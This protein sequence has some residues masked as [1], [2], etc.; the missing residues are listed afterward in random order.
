MTTLSPP[1]QVTLADVAAHSGV[2]TSSV[3]KV[4]NL[5]AESYRM[6]DQTRQRILDA[7]A[8]LGYRPNFRARSLAKGR[9][10]TIGVL[11]DGAMPS[12]LRDGDSGLISGLE[13]AFRQAEYQMIFLP[14]HRDSDDWVQLLSDRRVDGCLVVNDLKDYVWDVLKQLQLPTVLINALSDAP[15]TTCNVENIGMSRTLTEHLILHGHQRIWMYTNIHSHKHHSVSERETGYEQAM[16]QANL[17]DHVQTFR[18]QFDAFVE[19]L[20]T[21]EDRPT[22]IVVYQHLEAVRL[23][24]ALWRAGIRV[25]EEMSV[26]TFNNS[27]PV[28]HVIPPLTTM[29]LPNDEIGR[30]AAQSLLKLIGQP[31]DTR[32]ADPLRF[33]GWQLIVRESTGPVCRK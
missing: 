4:L 3:S 22:A 17:G 7:V 20:V 15:L 28:E 33:D 6:S 8:E 23:L 13:P 10:H 26:A 19:H 32:N 29:A 2:S 12:I 21:A 16:R 1:I 11:F 24:Q 31:V 27:Y 30:Q 14:V 18:M 5:P 25:P 9:S